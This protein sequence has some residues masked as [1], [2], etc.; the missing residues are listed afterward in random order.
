MTNKREQTKSTTDKTVI[1]FVL[2]VEAAFAHIFM[3]FNHG[4]D[5]GS[6]QAGWILTRDVI[7]F[8]DRPPS[9]QT[10]R[11]AGVFGL[12]AVQAATEAAVRAV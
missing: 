12:W 1:L 7:V 6:K 5:S 9:G 11:P 8:S 4:S 10:Y 2:L 3:S